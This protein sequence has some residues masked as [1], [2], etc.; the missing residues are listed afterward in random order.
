M[1]ELLDGAPGAVIT[2]DF[3]WICTY[4]NSQAR[5]DFEFAPGKHLLDAIPSVWREEWGKAMAQAASVRERMEISGDRPETHQWFH[6]KIQPVSSGWVL[7]V[8][9]L[10]A[11]KQAEDALARSE[12]RFRALAEATLEGVAIHD[13][14]R[15][16]HAN[17]A[18]ARMFGVRIEDVLGR[19]PADFAAPGWQTAVWSRIEQ[20]SEEPYEIVGH[21]ADGSMFPLQFCGREV[22]V[23]GQS[24]RVVVARD[25]SGQRKLESALRVSEEK[26]RRIIETAAEGIWVIDEAGVTTFANPRMAELLGY[27]PEEMMGRTCFSFMHP[28]DVE[29]GEAGLKRRVHHGDEATRHYRYFHKDGS[30]RWFSISGSVVRDDAGEFVG[31]LGMF[32]DVTAARQAEE[33][34]RQSEE[35]LRLATHAAGLGVWE[36]DLATGEMISSETCKKHV[37]APVHGDLTYEDLRTRIHPADREAMG[38]AVTR[39]IGTRST[40]ECEYRVLWPDGTIH[41]VLAYGRPVEDSSGRVQRMVGVTLDTT[42]RK[43]AEEELRYHLELTQAITR[44][45]GDAIFLMDTEGRLT[46][47]NPAAE[48]LSGWTEQDM[49]GQS[50]HE[51]LHSKRSDG[52]RY[53]A[54]E[55]PLREVLESGASLR[56]HEDVFWH[57]DGSPV[58]VLC[59]T[60]PTRASGSITG[61]VIVVHD[62]TERKR[63]EQEIRTANRAL[64]NSN[65]ELERFAFVASHDLQEPLRTVGALSQLLIRRYSNEADDQAK[66]VCGYIQTAV[67]RM[68]VLIRDLLAYSRIVHDSP[69]QELHAVADLNISL[70][71]AVMSLESSIAECDAV[72]SVELLPTVRGDGTQ[73]TQVFQNLLSNS[74]KYRNA[75]VRPHIK[76][77]AKR[78][79]CAWLVCVADNGF[80]FEPEYAERIF[81]LFRRLHRDEYPGTGLGL[82]ICKRI[83]E[84]FGGRIWAESTPGAGAQFYFSLPAADQ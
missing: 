4:A 13:G 41:W 27:Q 33:A 39:S 48:D 3:N 14:K 60:A 11:Y 61:A 58:N 80:G 30:V 2:L 42:V 10:S 35:T 75:E 55:C 53:P 47:T 36:L 54:S 62:I 31:V 40:Y 56:D 64:R 26:Y 49:V 59:S 6:V 51:L 67:H 21:R 7:F 69:E 16:M 25:L 24:S 37:G 22:D 20:R 73:L 8:R 50:F 23:D 82:A 43:R 32:T 66:E 12:Q 29:R 15:I 71:D 34:L 19:S 28:D 68:E 76:V 45:A 77:T 46:F 18:W 52:T 81:G 17:S 5:S 79:D 63:A 57:K 1:E 78:Q 72:I 70:N 74:L 65:A 83:L 84:R 9:D 44:N 38:E